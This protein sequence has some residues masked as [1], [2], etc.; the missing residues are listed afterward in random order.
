MGLNINTFFRTGKSPYPVERTLLTTC[1]IDA[2]MESRYALMRA[3][4]RDG[5]SGQ[6]GLDGAGPPVSMPPAIAGCAYTSHTE[7]PA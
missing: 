3:N 7:P 1:V 2:V 5:M 4:G 6:A